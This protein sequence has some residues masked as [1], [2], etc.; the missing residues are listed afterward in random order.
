MGLSN[1]QLLDF[2]E[3]L[4]RNYPTKDKRL[5]KGKPRWHEETDDIRL[6][7]SFQRPIAPGGMMVPD[8]FECRLDMQ[9]MT[10]M[11]ADDL[12][13]YMGSKFDPLIDQAL[14]QLKA[15][16]SEVEPDGGS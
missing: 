9:T 8:I 11:G 1:E 13:D 10:P 3:V 12:V 15:F 7:L 4:V 16:D 6:S 14:E 2:I 5:R